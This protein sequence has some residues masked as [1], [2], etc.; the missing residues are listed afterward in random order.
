[1]RQTSLPEHRETAAAAL[2]A[3]LAAG[4]T[5]ADICIRWN[6]ET[7]I[8]VL[9]GEV[10]ELTQ[11]GSRSLGIRVLV[12][13][14]QALL[15]SADLEPGSLEAL[16]REAVA[17]ARLSGED[18]WIEI[19]GS[20]S[21]ASFPELEIFDPALLED[22]IEAKVERARRCETA[23]KT[24]RQIIGNQGTSWSELVSVSTLATSGGFLGEYRET[25]VSLGTMPVA[26]EKGKRQTE[27]WSSQGR[28]LQ[29][30][31]SPE[32]VG[33]EAGRRALARL[34][35]TVPPTGPCPV[36]LDPR[37]AAGLIGQVA[38]ASFG[39]AVYREASFL[40]DRRGEKVAAGI[41]T[42]VDDPL[43]RRG[44]ASR[45]FD[46]EGLPSRRNLL[47][48]KGILAAY[49]TD[50]YS[51]KKLE[52]PRTH[53]ASRGPTS[54]PGVGVTNLYLEAGKTS[55]DEI[56]ASLDRGVLVTDLMGHGVN[57]VTGDYSRSASGFLIE[58]GKVTRPLTGFTIAGNLKT[59]L[60]DIAIIG[61]DLH[62]RYRVNSPTLLIR[63]MVVSGS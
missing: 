10:E 20:P 18:P 45:P 59:M 12:G 38:A 49:L 31:E 44:L 60:E 25:S 55:P 32:V 27:Y 14:K 40:K 47:I 41:V 33:R 28:F 2:K 62:F 7:S 15:H 48:E 11:A 46:G 35:S 21:P 30:L 24:G 9:K 58:N 29:D 52:A 61:S 23:A 53:S 56:V 54:S 19:P 13:G 51:A 4:A 43:R 16:A 42:L 63:S 1:M 50:S 57:L 17:L 26:R 8:K 36:V 6:R 22:P 3:A 37:M 5:G 39:S 34:G